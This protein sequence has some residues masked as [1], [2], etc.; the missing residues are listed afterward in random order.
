MLCLNKQIIESLR[1][2]LNDTGSSAVQIAIL[3]LK[4]KSLTKHFRKFPKDYS[5]KLG[6]IKMIAKRKKLLKYLQLNDNNMYI[7]V[8]SA[9][10]L[11]K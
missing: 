5:S 10:G 9:L 3:T 11:R 6:F 2:H 8:T 1:L 7:T 4:I